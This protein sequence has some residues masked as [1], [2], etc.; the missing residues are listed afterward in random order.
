MET[1]FMNEK[2]EIHTITGH[3]YQKVIKDTP[4]A[5]CWARA[6]IPSNQFVQY[7]HETP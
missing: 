1:Y 3:G 4:A 2:W 6:S 7:S 5:S